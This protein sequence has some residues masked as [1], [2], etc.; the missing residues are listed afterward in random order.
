MGIAND[1]RER[2]KTMKSSKSRTALADDDLLARV[3]GSLTACSLLTVFVFFHIPSL[4]ASQRMSGILLR[5][6]IVVWPLLLSLAALN[7]RFNSKAESNA[8]AQKAAD[9]MVVLAGFSVL[10][11]VT[12]VSQN[13]YASAG[14]GVMWLA[15][16][17]LVYFALRERVIFTRKEGKQALAIEEG[18]KRIGRD[19]FTDLMWAA[20]AGIKKEVSKAILNGGHINAQ[21]KSGCTALIFAVMNNQ[22][23][24]V[25]LLLDAG[26]DPS[27]PTR[28]G[29]SAATI[30]SDR[31]LAAISELL[32]LHL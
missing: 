8:A 1:V 22:P 9:G 15:G 28:R 25:N 6:V 3:A 18:R 23:E 10:S 20:G 7:R 24:V 31:N 17:L 26:A 13:Q 21:D 12:A 30:A 4:V 32:R 19:G 16:T 11:V 29:R 5:V 14:L 27:I 2:E